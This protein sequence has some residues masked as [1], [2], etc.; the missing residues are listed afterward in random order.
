[1]NQLNRIVIML[2]KKHGAEPTRTQIEAALKHFGIARN[3]NTLR[4]IYHSVKL[5]HYRVAV[6]KSANK[7]NLRNEDRTEIAWEDLFNDPKN[8]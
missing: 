6:A 2:Y 5:L 1:M 7:S 8:K 4:Y 3:D